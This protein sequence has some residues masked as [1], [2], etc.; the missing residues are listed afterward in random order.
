MIDF[1]FYLDDQ[2]GF[3]KIDLFGFKRI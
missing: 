1:M 2:D 3:E